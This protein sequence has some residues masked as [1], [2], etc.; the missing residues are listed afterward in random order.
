M[1]YES[2]YSPE[3]FDALAEDSEYDRWIEWQHEET[4]RVQDACTASDPRFISDVL[5][6]G[7]E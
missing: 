4:M 1:S 6:G 3:L 5:V 7:D 2:H